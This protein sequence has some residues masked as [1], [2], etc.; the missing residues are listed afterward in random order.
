MSKAEAK[1]EPILVYQ[2]GDKFILRKVIEDEL[3]ATSLLMAIED[4]KNKIPLWEKQTEIIKKDL[5]AY[6][7]VERAALEVQNKAIEARRIEREEAMK[8]ASKTA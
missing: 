4:L 6:Q 5:A 7:K 1:L 8:K 3:D 2:K